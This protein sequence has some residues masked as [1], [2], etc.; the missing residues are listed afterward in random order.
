MQSVRRTIKCPTCGDAVVW[1]PTNPF[2]PFCSERCK[3]IDLGAWSAGQ[4]T[5]PDPDFP[6]GD[7]ND[8]PNVQ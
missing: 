4:Y 8:D 1:S 6:A 5:I 3:N 2:R 7:S